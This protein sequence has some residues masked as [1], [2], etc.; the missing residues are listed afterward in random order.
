MRK[1]KYRTDF[2]FPNT[3]LLVG[4]GSIFNIA[5]NYY[6]FNGSESDNEADCKAIAS[7]WGM[8][9]QDFNTVFEKI[10]PKSLKKA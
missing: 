8:V 4:M 7:D 6:S 10:L 5:G 1:K 9:G 3:N 2:L